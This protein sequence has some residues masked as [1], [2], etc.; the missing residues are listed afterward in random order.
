MMENPKFTIIIPL[1]M[2]HIYQLHLTISCIRNIHAFSFN[3][4]IILFHSYAS[5]YPERIKE[6]LRNTDTYVPFENNPSQANVI[7]KGIQMAKGKYIILIGNDNFVH[8][9]WLSNINKRLGDPVCKIL[10]C[11]SD[12]QTPEEFKELYKRFKNQNHISY[13][14][15]SYLNF[16]GVTIPKTVFDDIGFIDENLPF[17]FWERDFNL[18]LE[19][20]GIICGA[21]L[22]SFMTTPQNMTRMDMNLPDGLENW[23]TDESNTK[24]INY[25]QS[26]W[27]MHP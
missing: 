26:K 27:G 16:Q 15:F 22:N 11:N 23:W 9:G 8:Q 5:F 1:L 6:S 20:K 25:F 2:Q 17:Y 3:Y 24:E 12:R 13:T 10:A 18:R 21:V 7:N 14:R 19:Q 4:E